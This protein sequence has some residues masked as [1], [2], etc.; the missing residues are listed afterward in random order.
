MICS[1]ALINMAHKMEERYGIPYIE[2]SIYGVEDMNNL[3]RNIAA[4]LGD[5]ALQARVEAV[6]QAETEQLTAD[7]APYRQR[8]QESALCFIPAGS[9][10]GRSFLPQTT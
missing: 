9:K 5:V 6:I 10:A 7:L 2:A 1:K 4:K 3:L 8:L